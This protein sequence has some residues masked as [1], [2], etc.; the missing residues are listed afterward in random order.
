MD[1]IY[2]CPCRSAA[3]GYSFTLIQHI[4]SNISVKYSEMIH[5]PEY[6]RLLN[7]LINGQFDTDL[8]F[9]CKQEAF[10]LEQA[11]AI[12]IIK[13]MKGFK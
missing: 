5:H 4:Q 13:K 6:Q 8:M 1:R 9:E 7:E 2:I 12:Y 10:T 11:E 3:F